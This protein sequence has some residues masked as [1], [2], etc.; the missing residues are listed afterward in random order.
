[1]VSKAPEVRL[2]GQESL[3]GLGRFSCLVSGRQG[4]HRILS[5]S[6]VKQKRSSKKPE[7]EAGKREWRRHDIVAVRAA[8]TWMIREA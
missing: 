7:Q 6:F 3:D 5:I 1:M 8:K 2:Q 4:F